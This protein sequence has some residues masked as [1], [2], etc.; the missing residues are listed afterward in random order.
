MKLTWKQIDSFVKKPDPVARVILVY[1]PDDGLMRERARTMGL[2]V[3]AD[4]NDPFNVAVLENDALAADPARLPDEANAISMMGGNRLIRVEN[5]SDKITKIIE[6]YLANPSP[7]ALVI[8]EAGE[9]PPKSKLR[10]LCEKN[11]SA[12]A[13]PCYVEDERDLVRLIREVL[14]ESKLTIDQDAV[15]WL[16]SN[17]AGDRRRARREIEKL[18][19]FKGMDKSS[20]TLADARACCGEAGAQSLDDLVFGAAGG[21]SAVALRAWNKLLGEEIAF[22]SVLRALQNHFRRL[23]ITRARIESGEDAESAMKKLSP[24]VFFK[25]ADAFRS[26][27]MRWSL[28]AIEQTLA[29]ISG[30]EA[31]CKQTAMPPE[32]LCAQT[33]LGISKSVR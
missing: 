15:M 13:L 8:L 6:D 30:V 14:S 25:Q 24:P 17:I 12:A 4:Y 9:L 33:I 26:Q 1:G 29:K 16:A 23:H 7:H 32:T 27:T 5:A 28:P 3:V 2:A 18:I 11:S 20:I 21:N 19:T 31:Q 22:M 10:A